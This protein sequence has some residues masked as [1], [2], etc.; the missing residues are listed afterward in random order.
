MQIKKYTME[1]KYRVLPTKI[2]R[3]RKIQ[4]RQFE[5]EEIWIEYSI[6]V[7]DP[8]FADEANSSDDDSFASALSASSRRKQPRRL[9]APTFFR[10]VEGVS[11]EEK[12]SSIDE[13]QVYPEGEDFLEA[14]QPG[15]VD[16]PPGSDQQQPE[17]DASE[18]QETNSLY[19][20]QFS[21]LL[22]S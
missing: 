16:Q 12:G 6:E 10:P 20:M 21:F 22:N 7:T 13:Q 18:P 17:E 14:D 4:V 8:N 1:D 3:S 19:K 11:T 2:A 15:F 5:P 9:V